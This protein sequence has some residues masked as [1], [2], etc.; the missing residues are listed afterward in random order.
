MVELTESRKGVALRDKEYFKTLLENYKDGGVIF[1]AM[2]NV[3]QLNK[4]AKIK[5][6]KL[7]KEIAQTCEN[8]KKEIASFRR[9]TAKC[10]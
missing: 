2:C 9:S 1:L 4:E 3:Y 6:V 8:A 7:E 10:R 5:K